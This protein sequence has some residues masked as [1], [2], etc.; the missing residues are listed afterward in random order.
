MK[1]ILVFFILL[2][3]ILH[4][5]YQNIQLES[6]E[7]KTIEVRIDGEVEK[8]GV[9]VLP[10]YATLNDLILKCGLKDDADIDT[11][12]LSNQLH[13]DDQIKIYKKDNTAEKVSINT[14]NLDQ[15]ITLPGI[16]EK[17]AQRII[18]YRN[19]NGFFQ[20]LEDIKNV[21]GIGDK[22]YEKILP[23]IKL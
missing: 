12:N 4:V 11:L 8:P 13:Q 14:S 22:K 18:D 16:R 15:L 7:R 23:F 20:N 10:N 3:F 21:K 9:Y 6:Q 17:I 1:R 5:D 19:E 2:G